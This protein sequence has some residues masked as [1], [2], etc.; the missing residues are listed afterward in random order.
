MSSDCEKTTLNCGSGFDQCPHCR[1]SSILVVTTTGIWPSIQRLRCFALGAFPL[2]LVP[3]CWMHSVHFVEGQEV[4]SV[5]AEFI[6]PVSPFLTPSRPLSYFTGCADYFRL[7]DRT[8]E[9]PD[10]EGTSREAAVHTKPQTSASSRQQ[11]RTTVKT[12]LCHR[13]EPTF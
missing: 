11:G 10:T 3:P 2:T 9:L 8:V 6:A 7:I 13:N 1:P 12:I 5:F 4:L